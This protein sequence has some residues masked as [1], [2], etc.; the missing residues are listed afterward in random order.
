[1][2]ALPTQANVWPCRVLNETNPTCGQ[3]QCVAASVWCHETHLT[4]GQYQCMVTWCVE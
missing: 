3:H 1:V 2:R 4:G